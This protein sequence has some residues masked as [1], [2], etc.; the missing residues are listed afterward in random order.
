M[1]KLGED[2]KVD[3]RSFRMLINQEL[4]L[5]GQESVITFLAVWAP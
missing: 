5:G 3:P 4:L 2:R 1:G